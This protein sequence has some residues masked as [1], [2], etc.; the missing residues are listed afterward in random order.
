M[1]RGDFL[2]EKITYDENWQS[3]SSPEF[4]K[5]VEPDP[6]KDKETDNRPNKNTPKH[7][8][9]TAQLVICILI[10]IGA[11]VLKSVGGDTYKNIRDWYFSELNNTAIF[12]KNS[13]FDI[14]TLLNKATAD[15]A[16]NI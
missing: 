7:Y 5:P 13:G 4:P 11:F 14:N 16:E 10:V 15:E 3:L 2:E 8:L 1:Y 12:D 6:E 9:L